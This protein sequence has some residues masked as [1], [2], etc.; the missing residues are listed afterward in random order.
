MSNLFF[1]NINEHLKY[2]IRQIFFLMFIPP[3]CLAQGT[4]LPGA[5]SLLESERLTELR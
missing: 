5:A 3:L 1:F 2:H 4:E